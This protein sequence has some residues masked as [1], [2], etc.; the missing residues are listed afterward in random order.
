KIPILAE[1]L[2][3]AHAGRRSL[4]DRI[5]LTGEMKA[6]GSGVLK[7]LSAGTPLTVRD[8]ATLMIIV[9]DNT[10]TDILL[11]LLTKE[12]VNSRL[13]ACGLE[14][15]TVAMSC[16]ELLNDLVGLGGAPDSPENRQVA[17]ERLKR[18]ELDPNSRVYRDDRANTTTPR[19]MAGLLG[20][21]LRPTLSGAAPGP[22][23]PEVC[24]QIAPRARG[25]HRAQ[26]RVG[27]PGEQRRRDPVR[28]EIPLHRR[29]LHEG[30][31]RRPQGTHGDRAGGAGRLR[32]LLVTEEN[33]RGR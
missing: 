8:L 27:E 28:A 15:T 16:R 14:R 25:R 13:R 26:N 10:A 9:S 31:C 22:L 6:P 3:Q 32:G 17:A 18:R 7:E 2:Y 21:V 4:D 11:G 1:L 23:P 29:G 33:L 24:R 5:I 20:H 19:E 12:A 30:P